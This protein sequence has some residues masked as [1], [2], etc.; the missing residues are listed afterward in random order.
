MQDNFEQIQGDAIPIMHQMKE[1]GKKVD[2]AILSPPFAS[3]YSYSADGQDMSN[4]KNIEDFFIHMRFFASAI[5]DVIKEG[6]MVC[7]HLMNGTKTKT[8]DGT[9]GLIDL[10]G[11]TVRVFQEFGFHWHSDIVIKKSAMRAVENKP[12]P[13]LMFGTIKRNSLSCRMSI[14]DRVLVFR[15]GDSDDCIPVKP[16]ENEEI[17]FDT[18]CNWADGV[19]MDIDEKDVVKMKSK[20]SKNKVSAFRYAK[21]KGDEK[22]L[23]PTQREVYKRCLVL[24]SNPN[25]TLLDPFS[26]SGTCFDVGL[27]MGR[28]V[29]GIDLKES[30]NELSTEVGRITVDKIEYFNN[31]STLF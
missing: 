10:C 28:K 29:I 15:N 24:Y 12:I 13:P 8:H 27:E 3:L 23:T 11:A 22:H 21:G 5:K 31:Q 30:Y 9:Q 14:S 2:I 25:E 6:R 16:V 1:E 20:R 26:G 17:D 4:C 19:W 7:I 18:W